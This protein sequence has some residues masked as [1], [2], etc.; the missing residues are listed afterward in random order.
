M[1]DFSAPTLFG[2]QIMSSHLFMTRSLRQQLRI[3]VDEQYERGVRAEFRAAH[4]SKWSG[5][6]HVKVAGDLAQL[7]NSVSALVKGHVDTYLQPSHTLRGSHSLA[8]HNFPRAHDRLLEVS[9]PG[10]TYI[11]KLHPSLG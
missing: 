7:V 3:L 5:V 10:E 2:N 9:F 8:K 4:Q 1:F 6:T 11:C